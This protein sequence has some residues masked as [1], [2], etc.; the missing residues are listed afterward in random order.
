ME[1]T[2]EQKAAV[3]TWLEQGSGLSD[4]QKRLSGEFGINMTYMDVRFLVLDLGVAPQDKPEPKPPPL[5]PEDVAPGAV[6]GGDPNAAPGQG[7]V[8]VELDRITKPG[9]AMSGT[10][11]FSDGVKATWFVDQLGRL[12]LQADRED[13]SPSAED[14]REF[15]EALRA[16]LG[17]GY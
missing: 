9:S 6:P 17:G 11:C 14:V 7:N 4:V 2:D 12:A 5:P 13:Y 15:Q 8:T 1:L 3:K 10:V 16:K